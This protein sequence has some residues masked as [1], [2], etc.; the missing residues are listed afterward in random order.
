M[1]TKNLELRPIQ[2][3]YALL[4]SKDYCFQF[5]IMSKVVPLMN[6]ELSRG[7]RVRFAKFN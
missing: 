7:I 6:L 1:V 5:Q 3:L 2:V 4:Q